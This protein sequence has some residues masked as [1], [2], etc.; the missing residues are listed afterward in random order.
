MLKKAYK[1]I[2]PFVFLACGIIAVTAKG[3]VHFTVFGTTV[4]LHSMMWFLMA[5]AHADALFNWRRNQNQT[6]PE[7]LPRNA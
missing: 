3:H 7:G 6:A 4:D 2:W 1:A 5:F